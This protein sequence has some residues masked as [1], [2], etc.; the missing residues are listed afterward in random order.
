MLILV[1]VHFPLVPHV[2]WFG[3]LL[4][5]FLG[6]LIA[7]GLLAAGWK[8]ALAFGVAFVVSGF[9]ILLT[10][11]SQRSAQEH[12]QDVIESGAWRA[13]LLAITGTI[14]LMGTIGIGKSSALKPGPLLAYLAGFAASGALGGF[15]EGIALRE[16]SI[17]LYTVA[18]L[19]QFTVAGAVAGAIFARSARSDPLPTP[20]P[21]DP[22]GAHD[23]PA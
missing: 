3:T 23:L 5:M 2:G 6:G 16:H 12:W 13:M 21:R 17:A 20:I 8:T 9:V 18:I 22:G 14:G 15:L 1:P 11:V 4:L 10:S 19:A 7:G